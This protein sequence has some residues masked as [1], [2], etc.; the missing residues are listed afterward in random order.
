MMKAMLTGMNGTVAPY[1]YEELI[2]RGIEVIIWDRNRNSMHTEEAVYEYIDAVQPDLFFHIATGPVEWVK[3]IANAA[4]DLN[5]KLIYTSSV[6]VFSDKGT[7]PYTRESIPNADDDYGRYKIEGEEAVQTY[8]PTAVI[9]RLGWQIGSSEGSNNM[10]DFLHKAEKE[11]G[12]IEASS[13]WYPSCSFLEDTAIALVD[14]ALH[15]EKGIYLLN[16]NTKYS[17]FEIVQHLKKKHHTKWEI[18]DNS[19]FVR[20]DRMYDERVKIRKFEF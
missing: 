19:S 14:I 16:S 7:G 12:F 11:N 10:L 3:H 9:A 8:N 6:S 4:E 17:F 5:I 15:N 20:D 18:R 13:K 2:R 1:I